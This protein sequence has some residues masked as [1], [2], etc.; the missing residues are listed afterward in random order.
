MKNWSLLWIIFLVACS[1]EYI[2]EPIPPESPVVGEQEVSIK[3]TFPG[4]GQAKTKSPSTYA[5][6]EDE[7]NTVNSLDI[8]AFASGGDGA[9]PSADIFL[10]RVPV[11]SE[12]IDGTGTTKTVVTSLRRLPQKQRFIFVANLPSS[13][14]SDLE[15]DLKEG[16]TQEEVVALLTFDGTPWR[17]AQ[18]SEENK[19]T[20]IPMWGQIKDS[21]LI[22]SSTSL[23]LNSNKP[24]LLIRSMAKI[25]VSVAAGLTDFEIENIFVCNSCDSGYIAPD[26]DQ[27]GAEVITKTNAVPTRVSAPVLYEFP[28]GKIMERT[29]YVPETDTLLAEDG[30]TKPAY[31]VIHAKYKGGENFYRVDFTKEKHLEPLLRNHGYLIN[32]IGAKEGY[33]KFDEAL[34]A[35]MSDFNFSLTLD[36][37]KNINE[38]I[39]LG[40][41]YMLGIEVSEVLFD[42]DMT[43]IGR[44][45]GET[46]HFPLH[47][48]T[49]YPGGWTAE[50]LN[51]STWVNL[52]GKTSG[53]AVDVDEIT[54][55]VKE[56]NRTGV[57]RNDTLIIRAGALVKKIA[58]RQSGGANSRMIR[59]N[60]GENTATTRI[61][62]AFADA[63]RGGNFFSSISSDPSAFD[64]RIIWQEAGT[65]QSN[66]T[67]KIDGSGAIKDR[68]LSVTVQ[69]GMKRSGNAVVA[70]IRKG[71]G[72][73]FVGGID[74]DE[75]LWSWHVWYMDDDNMNNNYMDKDYHNPN[76]SSFMKRAL[77]RYD[78]NQG[79][80]YQWGR[81]DPFPKALTAVSPMDVANLPVEKADNLSNAIKNP[82]VFYY[83]VPPTYPSWTGSSAPASDL[84]KATQ[85]TKTYNDPC[86]VGWRV[87]DDDLISIYWTAETVN[88]FS[89]GHLSEETGVWQSDPNDSFWTLTPGKVFIP[90]GSG[91]PT[92]G[93]SDSSAGRPV[94]CVKDIQLIKTSL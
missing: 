23:N 9:P 35:P 75:V 32:I 86:P 89:R 71:S 20:P 83:I 25:E 57:E 19:Y 13:L 77:G 41:Q 38:V 11:S 68:A 52:E 59:F 73:P 90:S 62:L 76:V 67:V 80:F 53:A 5:I 17:S 2:I 21:T 42:W 14:S 18:A 26:K 88:N 66:V 93:S 36:E 84:W 12:K 74:V 6:S 37:T 31:L 61:P 43:R 10:Y 7:E 39:Y 50:L 24:V 79:M 78:G 51:A 56:E 72:L 34:N 87:P 69:A 30:T 94:R 8:F 4:S 60:A 82:T 81:K 64:A 40:N 22:N 29:I 28:S 54:I 58:I 92:V 63:A 55:N 65:G 33:Q 85:T 1:N 45:P 3:I 46:A 44:L 70:I 15:N 91:A 49:T 27:W 16:M 47:V 48:L